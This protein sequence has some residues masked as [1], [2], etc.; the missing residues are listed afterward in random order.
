MAKKDKDKKKPEKEKTAFIIAPIGDDFS[1]ERRK[2]DGLIQIIQPVLNEFD[3]KALASHQISKSGSITKQII[4]HLLNDD[5]VICNLTGLNP[6]VMYELAVRHAAMF[7]CVLIAE[8]GTQNPFDIIDERTIKFEDDFKGVLEFKSNL[9]DAIAE[10]LKASKQDNPVSDAMGFESII[11]E[12][13]ASG[14]SK[15]EYLIEGMSRLE[16][17]MLSEQKPYE[18]S[19]TEP[20]VKNRA[21]GLQ[22]PET[23]VFDISVRGPQDEIDYFLKSVVAFSEG[24][25][26]L[27]PINREKE[28][29]K[30][31]VKVG[32]ERAF[33]ATLVE[34]N[35]TYGALDF[36]IEARGGGLPKY[37]YL[38][39]R[40]KD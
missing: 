21:L 39:R 20:S 27:S 23:A 7:P 4:N 36:T 8:K 1:E 2:I 24:V 32:N 31:T 18:I 15:I 40:K 16:K 34:F 28:A 17:F 14:D 38:R 9:R 10:T 19:F 37:Q 30:F 11:K 29:T 3:L 6:N 13:K 35:D 25:K 26:I 12:L 33:K 22:I 5:L